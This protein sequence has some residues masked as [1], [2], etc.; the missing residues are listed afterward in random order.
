M[1][2]TWCYVHAWSVP[3]SVGMHGGMQTKVAR[4]MMSVSECASVT[5]CYV[6]F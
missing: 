6:Q 5:C 1:P 3:E 4:E 2:V